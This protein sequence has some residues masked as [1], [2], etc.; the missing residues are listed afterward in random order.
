M[1]RFVARIALGAHLLFVGFTIVGGLLSL[2]IPW[3]LMP[4]IAA[5][6]WGGRMAVTRAACPLS[7]LEDW[8]R[9]GAG[10]PLLHEE[11]FVAHYFE[12][13]VYPRRWSRRVEVAVGGVVFTSWLALAT[14]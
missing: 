13:R 2:V 9:A 6:A 4:H 8:G 3:L 11:G 7:R 14:R 5:A 12:G 1:H 10:R